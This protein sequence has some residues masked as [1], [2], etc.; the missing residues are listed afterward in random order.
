MP[1]VRTRF[2]PS[3][4]GYM[5]I[6]GMRTAL[7]NWLWAR[8]N[9]GQFVLRIDD[10]DRERNVE[11]ALQ[12]ILDAFGWLELDWDE[13][14]EVGGEYGPYFQSQR[15][16]LY[17][18]AVNRLLAAGK[19]YEDFDPPE[20][21]QAD[22]AAAE[23][24][25][26]PYLNI[27]RSLE[28]S[29]AKRDDLKAQ[30][31]PYV[32]RF[33][34]PRDRSVA[35]DDHVRGRVEWDCGLISD[36]VIMRGDGSP[37]YN[38]ATVVDDA[39]MKISHVIRAEE[40]LT[41]TAV[42]ALLFQAL[43]FDL[44]EFAHIPFVAAPGSKEKLSKREKQIEKY[45]KSPQFK[46]LFD[47]ADRVF[48]LIGEGDSATLNP[49]MV[50]YYEKIGFLPQAVF[51]GLARLGWSYDDKTENMSR[52]FITENFTLD[53]V[54]KSSA[55]L[56]PDKL[57]AYQEYW[58]GDL[59]LDEKV[60]GCLPY[61]TKAGWITDPVTEDTRSFVTRLVTA[62]GERVKLFSD[63]LSY[64]EYFVDDEALAFDEKAFEKR[65][66]KPDEASQLLG[67]YRG[68]LATVEPF[69]A[70]ALD[71]D[72]HAFVEEKDIKIGQIIHAL[73]VA[74][75]GKPAGPG[76]F[77]CLALLGRERCIARIDRALAAC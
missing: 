73:R 67:E 37:L 35:I 45:R 4:T 46:K 55:G 26:Q 38:F 19:A 66:R 53:R 15:G 54:V 14:P 39:Q 23:Q 32:I 10:T 21:V 20:V 33:L 76:M 61:L 22:R 68:R 60:N 29:E 3:P 31:K 2:A 27:R 56:D 41:N 65:I 74:V 62:L 43:G 70:A 34:V 36:P 69:E 77:D 48:P 30:G 13:G 49:V 44:P 5:H 75:T 24:E 11:D 8:H 25:K 58:M 47:L 64:D 50:A 52:E 1:T 59:P 57:L 16:D 17:T 72:L 6:G 40:H 63:V 9:G 51:N 12:P 42:Q 18:E 71:A 7:F 28:L